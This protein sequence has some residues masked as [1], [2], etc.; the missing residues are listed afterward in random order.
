[1]RKCKRNYRDRVIRRRERHKENVTD[2]KLIK[3]YFKMSESDQLRR[4]ATVLAKH[5][6]T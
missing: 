1:M 4:V 6:A 5:K 2:V 3:I